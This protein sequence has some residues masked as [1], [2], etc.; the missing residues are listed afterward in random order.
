MLLLFWPVMSS[1]AEIDGSALSALW[2]LP[3]AGILLSIAL[4]PL[5][6]PSFWHH[7]FGKIS[8]AWTLAF[9]LPFAVVFGWS[10]AGSSL[11]HAL[12]A[13][14]AGL[15]RQRSTPGCQPV[16]AAVV[17]D[18]IAYWRNKGVALDDLRERIPAR[19]Y[20]Q[21]YLDLNGPEDLGENELFDLFG[22]A[23]FP[24]IAA[25]GRVT[26]TM[27]SRDFFWLRVGQ[28]SRG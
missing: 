18:Q 5:V 8:A 11:V 25:D 23:N 10:V 1:A 2:A 22:G 16:A 28:E 15:V 17:Y 14:Y 24:W 13:E 20:Y 27:G 9:F 26:F 19:A 21:K 12:L 4:V 3:F 6:L 7:H